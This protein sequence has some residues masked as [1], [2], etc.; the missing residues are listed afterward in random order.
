M[1]SLQLSKAMDWAMALGLFHIQL[2]YD[3]GA[4]SRNNLFGDVLFRQPFWL[5]MQH[6]KVLLEFTPKQEGIN[7]GWYCLDL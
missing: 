2:L 4:I 5:N 3:T 1:V 6:A 7:N